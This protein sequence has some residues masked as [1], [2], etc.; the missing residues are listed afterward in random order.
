MKY[1]ILFLPFFFHACD[2][3]KE[4]VLTQ[5]E[6]KEN[7]DSIVQ[8]FFYNFDKKQI[9]SLSVA[10]KRMKYNSQAMM[11]FDIDSLFSK[12]STK[13]TLTYDHYS[14]YAKELA[15]QGKYK[16]ALEYVG[17]GEKLP[18]KLSQ[19]AFDKAIIWAYLLPLGKRELM[20]RYLDESVFNDS[21]NPYYLIMRSQFYREDSLYDYSI[22][23]VNLALKLRPND[24]DYINLRGTFKSYK[25]D[26]KGALEDMKVLSHSHE[27]SADMLE[28][29]A[30]I[31]NKLGMYKELYS[32][33]NKSIALNPNISI[34]YGLRAI[35]RYKLFND[36]D[37]AIED[38]RKG[39]LLGDPEAIAYMKK[40]EAH[41]KTYKKS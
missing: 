16:K 3:P 25:G 9:D 29:R 12:A 34:S 33:I 31:Y 38:M 2:E 6:S 14:F 11:E 18:H 5:R 37:G 35:A 26:Y 28:Q 1:L 23:D 24:T 30:W 7:H 10:V 17:V 21:L 4:K 36:Y 13:M 15:L 8:L 20:Y 40:Y 41:Q 32:D 22:R 19:A 39:A 27:N